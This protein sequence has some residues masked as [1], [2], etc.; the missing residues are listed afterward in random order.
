MEQRIYS[1]IFFCRPIFIILASFLAFSSCFWLPI[2][3]HA[4]SS[5]DEIIST[6][7]YLSI[8]ANILW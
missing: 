4:T 5:I 1:P 3:L 7:I 6:G 2:S 8:S